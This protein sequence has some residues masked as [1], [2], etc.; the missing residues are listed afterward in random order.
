MESS[1]EI[2]IQRLFGWLAGATASNIIVFFVAS[3]LGASWDV[4]SPQLI[5]LAIVVVLTVLPLT[6]GA[7]VTSLVSKK[8][9]SARGVLVWAGFAL[10]LVS[11]PAG[12]LMSTD[13]TTGIAL[14]VMHPIVATAWLAITLPRK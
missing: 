5:N 10:A 13:P 4:G 2:S 9:L 3:W 1:S 7:W 6:L 12:L 14:V 11:A 8:S